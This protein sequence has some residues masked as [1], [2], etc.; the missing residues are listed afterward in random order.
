MPMN[1]ACGSPDTAR[2]VIVPPRADPVQAPQW[3]VRT[4][5]PGVLDGVDLDGVTERARSYPL[6]RWTDSST[7]VRWLG[8]G[9]A[10]DLAAR[11]AE[12]AWMIPTL[13][14]RRLASVSGSTAARSFLRYFGGIA[15]DPSDEAHPDWTPAGR[16]RFVLP[17]I[18]LRQSHD[19][20]PVEGAEIVLSG[21]GLPI[22]GAEEPLAIELAGI[23]ISPARHRLND[24]PPLVAIPIG[25]DRERWLRSVPLALEAIEAGRLRKI[26]LSRDFLLA[27]SSGDLEP[28]G[29]VKRIESQLTHGQMFCFRFDG[30]AAFLGATPERLVSVAGTTMRCD[31]LAG[32]GPRGA[33]GQGDDA[34]AA[35]LLSSDKDLREHRFVRDGIV[36]SLEPIAR[37]I[38]I[39]TRPSVL[40]LTGLHH[41]STSIRGSLRDGLALGE[42]L[43]R[44]HPTPAVGGSPRDLALEM[45]RRLEGRPRGW[46][47]GSVGWIAPDEADFAVAIRSG[48]VRGG[49]L[50]AT[51]GAGIVR[52]SDPE[53]E[54]DETARKADSFLSLFT[55]AG[56]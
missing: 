38:E 34:L 33:G 10:D 43:R 1:E 26:V 56:T 28:A 16:A 29:L 17:R 46:Y 7:G 44:L 42:L 50:R 22:G 14:K 4:L 47:A 45:I 36:A 3:V 5:E 54:W 31:C 6:I 20:S 12:S 13:C 18:I 8:W 53:A 40:R 35:L 49:S 25:G 55:K 32:T 9:A 24:L 30:D 15:F 41:L 48:I 52:G 51:A 2:R 37:W 21:G 11:D 23:G 19:G 27:S 39:E